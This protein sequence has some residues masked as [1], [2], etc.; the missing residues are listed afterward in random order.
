LDGTFRL[1]SL[2]EGGLVS[3]L[4]EETANFD[5]GAPLKGLAFN[6]IANNVALV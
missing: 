1:W 6:R 3:D 4:T 2:P 5:L